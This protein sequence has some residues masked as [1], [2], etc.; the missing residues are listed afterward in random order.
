MNPLNKETAVIGVD[1]KNTDNLSITGSA[2]PSAGQTS[3]TIY[4]DPEQERAV[5]KKFDKYV[6]P[7][8]FLFILLNFLDRK[9]P[10]SFAPSES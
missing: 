3:E 5:L 2:P 1:E 10:R 8:A 7:Q 6:L 4:V 9:S